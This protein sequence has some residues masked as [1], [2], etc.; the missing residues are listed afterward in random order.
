MGRHAGKSKVPTTRNIMQPGA[1]REMRKVDP[2]KRVMP[3]D[4][5]LLSRMKGRNPQAN[6][7]LL[8]TCLIDMPRV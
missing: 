4:F 8:F 1:G 6:P 5:Q 7:S 3:D 2:I